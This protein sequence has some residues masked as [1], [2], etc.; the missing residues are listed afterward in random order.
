MQLLYTSRSARDKGSNKI[1][2]RLPWRPDL[3]N[4]SFFISSL[5]VWI[6]LLWLTRH[7]SQLDIILI[8]V[9]REIWNSATSTKDA[10]WQITFVSKAF[11]SAIFLLLLCN[12]LFFYLNVSVYIPPICLVIESHDI[13][14]ISLTSWNWFL[15]YKAK[16]KNTNRGDLVRNIK[17]AAQSLPERSLREQVSGKMGSQGRTARTEFL[18]RHFHRVVSVWRRACPGQTQPPTSPPTP[19][20]RRPKNSKQSCQII[21]EWLIQSYFSLRKI[22]SGQLMKRK[23][24]FIKKFR[25]HG[26]QSTKGMRVMP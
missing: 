3:F 15:V 1:T 19:I 13:K 23:V 14:C 11:V 17:R 10:G 16:F 22:E 18:S 20:W 24:T 8:V 7:S 5:F 9:V 25:F 21:I 12:V 4:L 6:H 26:R 2:W